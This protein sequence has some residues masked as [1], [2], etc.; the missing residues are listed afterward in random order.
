M[1]LNDYN[2]PRREL[3]VSVSNTY[4]D[5]DLSGE[6][7]GTASA[8]KGIGPKEINASFLIR[9][10]DK[11]QLAAFYSIAEAT[12]DNSDL[13]T[14]DIT[15]RTANA[16]NV[17]Q[18]KFTGRLDCREAQGVE[19]WRVSFRLKEVL[20][21]AEKTEQRKQVAD[22]TPPATEGQLIAAAPP[23]QEN[24]EQLTGVEAVL[25]NIDNALA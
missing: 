11:N 20:S 8:H 23:A 12:D 7:S 5:D 3:V 1:Q 18:V 9:F 21:V 16:V 15:E 22:A 24:A 17:R 25:Q 10:I 19:A 13:V 2:V 4:A 6:T 14:Y